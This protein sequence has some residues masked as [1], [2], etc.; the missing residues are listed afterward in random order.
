MDVSGW[1]GYRNR[2][3]SINA[4]ET[5]EILARLL[6]PAGFYSGERGARINELVYA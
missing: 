2:T 4:N 5:G 6:R 3:H 1:C